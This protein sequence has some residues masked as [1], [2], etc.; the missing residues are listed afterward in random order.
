MKAAQSP[1]RRRP[2]TQAAEL[3]RN[4]LAD[5]GFIVGHGADLSAV[6]LRH[7]ARSRRHQASSRH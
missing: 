4:N 2:P 1:D 7:E 3:L 5:R 6:I